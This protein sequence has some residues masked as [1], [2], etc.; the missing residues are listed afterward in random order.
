MIDRAMKL[1]FATLSLASICVTSS[2]LAQNEI[3][4]GTAGQPSDML[5]A[6]NQP[7]QFVV[8]FPLGE[9][10]LDAQG[11]STVAAAADAYRRTGAANILVRGYTDTSGSVDFNQALSESREQ[12]VTDELVGL[13]VPP[14][15]ISGLA[16]GE[17]QLAVPTADGVPEEQNRRV[18]I[19]VEAPPPPP[20][21]EPAPAPEPAPQ[22]VQQPE[23]EPEPQREPERDRGQFTVGPFYGYNLE[24]ENGGTSHLAG[25]NFSFDYAVVPFL[26]IGLEQAAFYHF[27]TRDDGFGGRSAASLNFLL[28][29]EELAATAG[30]NIGYLYGSGIDDEFFAGPEVGIAAGGFSMKVAYDIPFSGRDWDEG[31]AVGTLGFGLRF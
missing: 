30:G 26:G 28:G 22:V 10:R 19:V 2:A 27:E 12:A 16:L 7:E 29:G 13:G 18:E 31:I 24:D 25:L 17:T 6:Q 3:N 15:A 4:S 1:C 9:A 21:P 23:P 8:Y 5:L 20:E 14:T 11:Q